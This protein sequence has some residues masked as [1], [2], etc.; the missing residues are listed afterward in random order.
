[1]VEAARRQLVRIAAEA[2]QPW[3]APAAKEEWHSHYYDV[4]HAPGAPNVAA[5]GRRK[6]RSSRERLVAA[7]QK[8]GPPPQ[9]GVRPHVRLES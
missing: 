8:L 7:T 4:E 9:P 3:G 2:S 1:M 6:A 5:A